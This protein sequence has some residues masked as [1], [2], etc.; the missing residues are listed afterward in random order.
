[1]D[2]VTVCAQ[3][4]K[5]VNIYQ[6]ENNN[7]ETTGWCILKAIWVNKNNKITSNEK[8]NMYWNN[9]GKSQSVNNIKIWV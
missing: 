6:T 3:I 1:M 4:N 9:M 8:V 7:S 2:N 5:N